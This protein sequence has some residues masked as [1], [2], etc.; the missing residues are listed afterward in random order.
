MGDVPANHA[1]SMVK[2]A[3]NKAGDRRVTQSPNSQPIAVQIAL[4]ARRRQSTGIGTS[5]YG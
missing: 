1:C 2:K 4:S 5:Y 3:E